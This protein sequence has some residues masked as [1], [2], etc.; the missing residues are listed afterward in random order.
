MIPSQM[1]ID[2][3]E[4]LRRQRLREFY[5]T[6]TGITVLSRRILLSGLLSE[7]RTDSDIIAHNLCVRELE[8]IGMLDEEGLEPLV[9]F[10]I[11]QDCK[12]PATGDDEDGN[13]NGN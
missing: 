4:Y 13:R 9:K 5:G 1:T 11:A 10:M 7:I 2:R 12:R 3:E 6:D 8:E